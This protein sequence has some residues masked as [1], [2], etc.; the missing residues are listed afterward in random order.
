M[1]DL[2]LYVQLHS[3]VHLLRSVM[4]NGLGQVLLQELQVFLGTTSDAFLGGSGGDVGGRGAGRQDGFSGVE[5]GELGGEVGRQG[6]CLG[7]SGGG[8]RLDAG[9]MGVGALRGESR[10]SAFV[11]VCLSHSS[12]CRNTRNLREPG[13]SGR[14]LIRRA[15]SLVRSQLNQAAHRSGTTDVLLP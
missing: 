15:I 11:S 13:I 12:N 4:G 3:I 6:G 5:L 8:V 14:P 10:M 9:K 1:L 7:S 2:C